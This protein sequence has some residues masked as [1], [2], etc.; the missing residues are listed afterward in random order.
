MSLP[1]AA[2]GPV[3]S[4]KD[5][6]DDEPD[7]NS[8]RVYVRPSPLG[9][10]SFSFYNSSGA[11]LDLIP[12]ALNCSWVEAERTS[13]QVRGTCRGWLKRSAGSPSGTLRLAPLVTALRRRGATPVDVSLMWNSEALEASSGWKAGGKH[14]L[15]SSL[16]SF[17]SSSDATVPGDVV[18][19]LDSHPNLIVPI[20]LVLSVPVLIAYA[21]RR[22]VTDAP[23]DRKMNWIVWMTWIH[24]GAWLY[25]ISVVNP[26]ELADFLLL[27]APLGNM[28]T[29]FLG[30]L[31]Y[32]APPLFTMGACLVAMA[33]LL[34]SS[35][36]SFTRLLRQQLVA[37][38]SVQVP[39]GI[40]LVGLGGVD[41]S[42]SGFS[43]VAAYLVYRGLAW[44]NW[45]MSYSEV[46]PL[47]SGELF[48]R[49]SAL[50]QK[51]GVKIARLS[52]LRTRV[53]EQANAFA[54]SGDTIVLTESLVRGLTPREV[55]AVIAHELGHHKAGHLRFDISKILFWV[56]ILGAGPGLGWLVSHFHLPT[57]SLTLP[58]APLAYVMLQGLLSQRRELDADARAALITGDPEGKIAALGRLAQLS[59]MP[60]EGGGIM[61]SIRSHPSMENRVLALARRHNIPDARALAI[62]RN[63]DEAYTGSIANLAFVI[64]QPSAGEPG[65]KDPV[66]TLRERAGLMEQTRWLHLLAP[67]LG[68]FFLGLALD[69]LASVSFLFYR[70]HIGLA[71]LLLGTVLLLWLELMGHVL[72]GSLFVKRMKRKIAARLAPAPHAVFA[73]IHP[74]SGVRFTEGFPE[75]DFGFVSL[76][77]DWLVYRGEKARFAILRQDVI[78]TSIVKGPIRWLREHRVE[79][80]FRGGVFTL[81]KDFAHPTQAAAA[82]TEKWITS[83]ISAGVAGLPTTSNPEPPPLLPRLPGVTLGRLAPLWFVAKTTL[84][85]WLAMPLLYFTGLGNT[86]VLGVVLVSFGAPLAVFLRALPDV[87]WP[88]RQIV[89]TE[90]HPQPIREP[91]AVLK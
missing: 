43:L 27:L 26:T 47:E 15:Y 11:F 64:D 86:L 50:A 29:L 76:E 82:R 10:V 1:I 36:Q 87:L 60:V 18:V 8:V 28:V 40:V 52:M 90:D 25:W 73:G 12:M 85:I 16:L 80:V 32:S 31:L 13:Y 62:L 89:D 4:G 59:R 7:D 35:K 22:R 77:G 14:R 37:Q 78:A 45:S 56:F 68:A 74:G 54:T 63:P 44:L 33:P 71:V 39:L 84:K 55:N 83:W 58:I 53:P 21:V 75:W 20:L 17:T 6:A 79:I 49:A 57:W 9:N 24:L 2:Q 69:K 61:E 42:T 91:Q 34:S 5:A 19:P 3:R 66:F 67:L 38:A 88:V 72:L 48:D 46:T 65:A 51:A 41:S 23:A 70:R 81:N 30:V